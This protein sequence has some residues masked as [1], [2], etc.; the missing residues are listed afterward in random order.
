MYYRL[1][2]T[3]G[4]FKSL[5]EPRDLFVCNLFSWWLAFLYFDIIYDIRLFSRKGDQ[6][7]IGDI[8]PI[9]YILHHDNLYISIFRQ[10]WYSLSKAYKV[11]GSADHTFQCQINGVTR[12]RAG[13]EG[14]RI[15]EDST[16]VSTK[17]SCIDKWGRP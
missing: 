17:V 3:V 8:D 14:I 12:G 11:L 4:F 16:K 15:V 13:T 7:L 1:E 5:I 10:I 9:L 2:S 6:S